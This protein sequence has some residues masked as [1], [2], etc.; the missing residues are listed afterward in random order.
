[1][2]TPRAEA[3]RQ[4]MSAGGAGG[5]GDGLSVK[6]GTDEGQGQNHRSDKTTGEWEQ[7]DGVRGGCDGAQGGG[8]GTGKG[9]WDG[10][11]GTCAGQRQEVKG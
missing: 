1:M 8:R 4:Q 5:R 11:G 7:G 6:R 9:C 3:W 2:K 10:G